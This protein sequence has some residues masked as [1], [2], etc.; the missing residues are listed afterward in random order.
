MIA[1]QSYSRCMLSADFFERF[2]E[3]L[4]DSHPAIP[5]MFA[6]TYF[7]RQRQLLK[8]GLGLLLSYGQKS[9]DAL[10]DRI[11]ARHSQAALDVPPELYVCFVDSLVRVVSERDP[12]F[13]ADVE[14]AW[15]EV[16]APGIEFMQARH[17]T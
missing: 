17:Q 10:L 1:Q 14:G 12:K 8:H 16:L 15:R 2:Y 7:P 5:P 9:D 11:A 13:D 4:L 3:I 6:E